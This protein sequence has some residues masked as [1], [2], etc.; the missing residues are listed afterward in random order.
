MKKC[1][2]CGMPM[3]KSS[4]FGGGRDGNRYCVH[5][6]YQNGE[7]KPRHEV[8][9]GMILHFMKMKRVERAEAE[10]FVDGHMASLPAWQ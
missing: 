5:C 6:T 9:E 3:M 7:L 1:E 2:S 10:K 8:R 4:D